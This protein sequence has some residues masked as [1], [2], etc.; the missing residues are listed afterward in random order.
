MA[1]VV[2]ALPELWRLAL[3]C[4]VALLGEIAIVFV[5]HARLGRQERLQGLAQSGDWQS[6]APCGR[7]RASSRSLASSSPS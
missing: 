2:E 6:L 7:P 3:T 4:L 5:S 1:A